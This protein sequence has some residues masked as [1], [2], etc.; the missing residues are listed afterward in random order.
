MSYPAFPKM[1]LW[2]R[3]R[4]LKNITTKNRTMRAGETG[5]I[6]GRWAYTVEVRPDGKKLTVETGDESALEIVKTK[7]KKS[8]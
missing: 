5:E 6:L 7:P 2:T 1:S 8:K 4:A 3:V